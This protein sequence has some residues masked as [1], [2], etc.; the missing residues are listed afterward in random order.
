M[1][2]RTL[3]A[4]VLAAALTMTSVLASAPVRAAT[5]TLACD[6]VG[7]AA[8]V[9]LEGAQ[10]WARQNGHA[11][12]LIPVPRSGSRRLDLYKQLLGAQSPAI[13]IYM[14]DIV[15]PGVLARSFV[16]LSK[17]AA[18]TIGQH[19]PG[20]VRN[21]T[22]NGR[23]IAMPWFTDAGLMFYRKDLLAR[24]K[25]PVPA[26]WDELERTAARIQDAERGAGKRDFWGYVWQARAYEGL[27]CA[28][29]EWMVGH[30]GGA[31]VREDGQVTIDNPRASS[32]LQMARNW[33]GTISPK[34]VLTSDEDDALGAFSAGKVAF[35]R[36]WPYAW[37][38]ANGPASGIR[39]QVGIA[40][41]PRGPGGISGATLGGQQL[42]VS[43]FS[44][45]QALAID[46]V[47]Y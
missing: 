26:T 3:P 16:D 15:W 46:L 11:I 9:C 6:A 27:S 38:I 20:I 2:W 25:L 19:F 45:N 17:P 5:L 14:I 23:L 35:M 29:L 32:A 10:Q 42:A 18:A 47:M 33:I 13:D 39:G 22:V 1:T 12:K 36:N 28:A 21:N 24:Y 43:R 4:A 31:I 40:P 34:S 37:A 7:L 30:G 44:R 8:E 41:L